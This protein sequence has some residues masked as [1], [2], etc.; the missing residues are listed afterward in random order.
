MGNKVIKNYPLP[1]VAVSLRSALRHWHRA[2]FNIEP[3]F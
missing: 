2:A 3:K 1:K